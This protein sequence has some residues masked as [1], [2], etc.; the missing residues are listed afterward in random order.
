M[1][2]LLNKPKRKSKYYRFAKQ[3]INLLKYL[4]QENALAVEH[5]ENKKVLEDLKM[6]MDNF[7]G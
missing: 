3:N 6:F 7:G 5:L 1:M 4:K 2:F